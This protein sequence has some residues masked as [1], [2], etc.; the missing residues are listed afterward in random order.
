[1]RYVREKHLEDE[2]LFCEPLDTTTKAK[3]IFTKVDSFFRTHDLRWELVIGVC[4]HGAPAMLGCR[5]GFQ[6]L[7]KE[8]SPNAI[9]TYCILHRQA[10]MAKTMSNK[11]SCVLTT[12]I[13]AVNFIKA[14][15]LDSRLFQELCKESDSA[16]QNLLLYTHVRWLSKGKVLKSLPFKKR[17]TR[18]SERVKTKLHNNL[19]D[20][21]FLI[22]LAFLNLSTASI[23]VC[24]EKK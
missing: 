21:S 5:S 17:N 20:N 6:T 18:V 24:K 2:F 15:A 13:K 19:A 3:D 1:M 7:V 11:L 23:W 10:L 14:N 16:F 22:L 4:T 12:V 9:A 8:K